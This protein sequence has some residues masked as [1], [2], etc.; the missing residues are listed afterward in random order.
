[1]TS[2]VRAALPI[3]VL[4]LTAGVAAAE[5][6]KCRST[7]T[8]A[9]AKYLETRAKTLAKC[10]DRKV[11]GKLPPATVCANEEAAKLTKAAD[12]LARLVD[13]SC[14]GADRACGGGDDDALAAIGWDL[15]TCP[16][17]AGAGCANALVDCGDVVDCLRC[18]ADAGSER[19]RALVF[20]DVVPSAD[21]TVVKCQRAIGKEV[22]KF[23]QA[24]A[25]ALAK[26]WDKVVKGNAPGPCPV[27]GDGKAAAAIAKAESKKIAKICK[28][29]G[30]DDR[31]CDGA[32]DGVPGT[33]G[34][35]DLAVGV[36]GFGAACPDVTVPGAP[37]SCA[38]AV[39]ELADL[40]ACVDCAAAF[41]VDCVDALAVPWSGALP[42]ECGPPAG[43]T[44][45]ATT[46]PTATAPTAT[47]TAATPTP[48]ATP[49]ATAACGAAVYAEDFTGGNG[50][51]WP[52]PWTAI[53]SVDVADI[54]TNRA[55]FRPT[56]SGYSLARL[57][58]P[59]AATDVEAR[60]TVE[61]EDIGQQGVGFYVRQNGGY[62]Q[63]TMPHGEGYAVFVEGFRG[64]QGIGVWREIDGNE[65]QI[66]I[67]MGQTIADGTRY[68][69]RFQA[70]QAD[71]GTTV[72]RAKMWPEAGAEPSGWAVETTDASPDL[73]GVS[74]GIAADSWSS[75]ISG[76][77]TPA[78]TFLDDVEIV[79]L[80]N[81]LAGIGA[82]A[83]IQETFQFTEGPRWRAGEGVLLFT[84]IPASTI[85][86]LTPPATV[87]VFRSPSDIAN[88]L[89]TDVNG[90]LLA[91]E[92]ATRRLTR[93]DGVGTVTP[94]VSTYLGD[95]FNSPNDVA[96]RS[97]GVLYFTDP[98]YGLADPLDR[99]IAFNG[100]FRVASGSTTAEWMGDAALS[101]PNGVVLAP[102]EGTLYLSDSEA[103][104]VRAFDVEPDGALTGER[105]F[106]SGLTIPDGMCVDVTGNLYVATWAGTVEIFAPGGEPWGTIAF[107][108]LPS[109]CAFGGADARTLYVTAH[110]G[111]YQVPMTIPGVP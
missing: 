55:R 100:L 97:D 83:P 52:A 1:M 109:N 25:K 22:T 6:A 14:G 57:Y 101:G 104:E 61:F 18:A 34:S 21:R 108:R 54:Q 50:D 81:P 4:V 53:G 90:D 33:G 19:L 44:A 86:R 37:G 89:A 13:R 96:V 67:D 59:V 76:G 20:D 91:C 78:H 43:P 16:D 38:G 45:T 98:P 39:T 64:F 48:T 73:Q 103:G 84:D 62:L 51:P 42:A 70:F 26:C 88:G 82:V 36:I 23:L 79:P 65:Q 41:E 15:G 3:L 92:H 10:E 68:R 71:A 111:L 85:Y 47:P 27:P 63:D 29:C 80:C 9:T 28:A 106:A 35:D 17:P 95:A 32:V 2:P 12:K 75:I 107:P 72:L 110:E 7:I 30:G 60:F 58:A 5:P 49:T 77:P 8:K 93:T 102:D 56:L 46:T 11:N 66:L 105:V 94:V 74:G 40:V 31:D 69:V 99:E 87:D 24:R